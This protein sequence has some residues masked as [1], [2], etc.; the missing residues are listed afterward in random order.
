MCH[1]V[2][3]RERLAAAEAEIEVFRS[4]CASMQQD[5]DELLLCLVGAAWAVCVPLVLW[6]TCSNLSEFGKVAAACSC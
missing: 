6:T 1:P 4:K 3:R 5:L 2:C